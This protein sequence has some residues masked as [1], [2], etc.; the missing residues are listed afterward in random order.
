MKPNSFISLVEETVVCLRLCHGMIQFRV[1]PSA[2]VM[3]WYRQRYVNAHEFFDY[4]SSCLSPILFYHH[5]SQE[6]LGNGNISSFND[7]DELKNVQDSV[8]VGQVSTLTLLKLLFVSVYCVLPFT[9]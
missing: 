9:P 2:A 6:K 5:M 1:L 8:L 7:G 4:I 3:K